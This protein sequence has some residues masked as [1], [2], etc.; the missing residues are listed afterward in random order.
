VLGVPS[1]PQRDLWFNPHLSP[2][3]NRA[4]QVGVPLLA[5][6]TYK[7]KRQ[8]GYN[9][10]TL[11]SVLIPAHKS[12]SSILRPA[13]MPIARPNSRRR[14]SHCQFFFAPRGG[15]DARAGISLM[16]RDVRFTPESRHRS[17]SWQCPLCA[18]SRQVHLSISTC[19]LVTSPHTTCRAARVL[20]RSPDNLGNPC[21]SS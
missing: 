12:H 18:K 5:V 6:K 19:A 17:A 14:P 7:R 10:D 20:K 21:R 13:R 1:E 2:R 8:G 15:R 4:V 3:G 11:Y 9:I 16:S